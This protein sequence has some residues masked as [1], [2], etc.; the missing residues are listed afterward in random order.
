MSGRRER[1]RLLFHAY[2]W[3]DCPDQ[4]NRSHVFR[5]RGQPIDDPTGY[6]LG[7]ARQIN[8]YHRPDRESSG[9]GTAPPRIRQV[10]CGRHPRS[11]PYLVRSRRPKTIHHPFRSH[12]TRRRLP[13][14]RPPHNCLPRSQSRLLPYCLRT[15][16]SYSSFAVVLVLD[17]SVAPFANPR[18]SHHGALPRLRGRMEFQTTR[19]SPAVTNPTP[20]AGAFD[21]PAAPESKKIQLLKLAPPD[22]NPPTSEASN[23]TSV[24][25]PC[26]QALFAGA[27]SR[28]VEP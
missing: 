5:N 25:E 19:R 10:F 23:Q 7:H 1:S 8:R 27:E 12:Q 3:C 21:I 26:A 4:P 6:L 24:S 11:T 28:S 16:K 22:P 13:R 18:P 20:P 14:H 9:A 17:R 15:L 2:P